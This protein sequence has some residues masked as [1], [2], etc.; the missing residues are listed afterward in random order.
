V[1]IY[2]YTFI[3]IYTYIHIY[4]H[5]YT[6]TH[7]HIYTHTYLLGPAYLP[8][9]QTGQTETHACSCLVII[10]GGVSVYM[11]YM[12]YNCVYYCDTDRADSFSRLLLPG[13]P[14][15]RGLPGEPG[16]LGR[17]SMPGLPGVLGRLGLEGLCMGRMGMVGLAGLG[18]LEGRLRSLGLSLRLGLRAGRGPCVPPLD[19]GRFGDSPGLTAS[20]S[21]ALKSAAL[22]DKATPTFIE[23]LWLI[24]PGLLGLLNSLIL[25]GGRKTSFGRLFFLTTSFF[26]SRL[27]ALS[28]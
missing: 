2:T 13:D 23:I 4:I 6:Y 19:L 10:I 20:N 9:R 15:D 3:H 5:I 8:G 1:S 28:T 11:V 7:I 26:P 27:F 18:G 21:S 24:G 14:G 17:E 25:E 16:V 22:S 12:V